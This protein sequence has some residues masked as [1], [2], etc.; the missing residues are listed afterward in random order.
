MRAKLREAR[1]Y[2]EWKKA[3][4]RLDRYLGAEAWKEE[5]SFAYYDCAT[6]RRLLREMRW[7]RERAGREGREGT[8][9][10]EL[11]ALLEMCVKNSFAG[12]ESARLYSQTYLGTKHLVQNFVDEG[13]LGCII[14]GSRC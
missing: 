11:R 8:A 13:V 10:G 14:W 7:L 6:V 12:I 2:S 1:T 3:A 9:V 5:D 4:E